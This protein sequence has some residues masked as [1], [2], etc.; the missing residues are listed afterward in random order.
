L[1]VELARHVGLLLTWR[2]L[3]RGCSGVRDDRFIPQIFGAD[4]Q[5]E[6]RSFGRGRAVPVMN[7]EVDRI[8]RDEI[9]LGDHATNR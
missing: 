9:K 4:F 5:T 1:L 2:D 7:E 3:L 6:P 8:G